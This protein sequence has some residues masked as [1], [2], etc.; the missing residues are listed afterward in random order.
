MCFLVEFK[1]SSRNVSNKN[2]SR[3]GILLAYEHFFQVGDFPAVLLGFERY[4]RGIYLISIPN[5]ICIGVY[6]IPD[7]VVLYHFVVNDD[8]DIRC[9]APCANRKQEKYPQKIFKCIFH[10]SPLDFIKDKNPFLGNI[11]F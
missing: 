9:F 5:V 11:Y 6:G 3:D 4:D 10:E 2:G 8:E 1:L 7:F